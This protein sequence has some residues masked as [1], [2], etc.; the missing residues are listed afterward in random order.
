M[1]MKNGMSD[2]ELL[3]GLRNAMRLGPD[4]LLTITSAAA[5]R[6]EQLMKIEKKTKG[7]K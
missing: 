4:R 5:I 6:L 7:D 3:E 2:E 1:P